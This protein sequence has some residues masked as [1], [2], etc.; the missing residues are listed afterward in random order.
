MSMIMIMMTTTTPVERR[1]NPLER[2]KERKE[3]N[4]KEGAKKQNKERK[5][6]RRSWGL[7]C[8]KPSLI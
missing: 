5:K 4:W 3:E 7:F 6:E 1:D 2:N 8:L